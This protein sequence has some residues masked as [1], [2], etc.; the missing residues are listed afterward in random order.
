MKKIF[1][2]LVLV[3]IVV[4][5]ILLF[6][7]KAE[8]NIS[9][10]TVKNDGDFQEITL[11]MKNYNYY[12]NEIKVKVGEPVRIILDSSVGGC[13]RAFTINELEVRKYSKSPE[14]YIEFTPTQKGIYRFACSMGMGTGKLIVE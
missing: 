4:L 11:S 13:Y 14:D 8:E 3:L 12:P 10:N 5:G 7:N 2:I 1:L 9:G 6:N